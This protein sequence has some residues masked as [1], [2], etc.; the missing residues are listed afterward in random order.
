ELDE[1]PPPRTGLKIAGI[2]LMVAA[3]AAIVVFAAT[4]GRETETKPPAPAA[5]I[6]PVP[7]ANV[8]PGELPA[9]QV[10]AA[11]PAPEA[12][13][14]PATNA[15]EPAPKAAEPVPLPPEPEANEFDTL[16]KDGKAAYD[17]GQLKKA[18]TL[19]EKAVALKPENDDG[20]VALA[21]CMMDR[22]MM[23]K[24]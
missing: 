4:G 9:P 8:A 16:L 22:G 18:Q 1:V 2:G 14:V 3:A 6:A 11:V 24:A 15:V 12:N 10:N 7:A 13:A 20:Q 21:L 17:R 23:G 19:L 5:N